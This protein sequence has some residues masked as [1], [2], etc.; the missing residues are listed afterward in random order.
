MGILDRGVLFLLLFRA[1]AS[2]ILAFMAIFTVLNHPIRLVNAM[3]SP[4][5]DPDTK[6][7]NKG[8][9][10]MFRNPVLEVLSLSSATLTV[11]SY[12]AIV[13]SFLVLNSF[14]GSVDSLSSGLFVYFGALACWT[15][16]EYVLHRYVFHFVYESKAGNRF[17]YVM[18][19]YHHEYP[20]D[21][22]RLF[23]PPAAGV[24]ISSIFLGIF[25]LL[26]GRSA[27]VFTAGFV[28]GYL[29]YTMMHYSIHRFKAPKGLRNLWKHH[30]MHHYKHNDR[31]FGVSS[32]FWDRIFGTMPKG[33]EEGSQA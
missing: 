3:N 32:T 31:A 17:H 1:N 19:G 24:I 29:L 25:F 5:T 14:F 6:I 12:G 28:N 9:V 20:R 15:F 27:F 16:F 2:L 13:L 21:A 23:M 33:Q 10:R 26:M 18:H 4:L 22:H 11:V 8:H 7:K 30:A